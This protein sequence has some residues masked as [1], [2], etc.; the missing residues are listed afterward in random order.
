MWMH[1][2]APTCTLKMVKMV[3]VCILYHNKKN[4]QWNFLCENRQIS[5]ILE[6]KFPQL[7]PQCQSWGCRGW[8]RGCDILA[9]ANQSFP[10]LSCLAGESPGVRSISSLSLAH[11][12]VGERACVS[13][14]TTEQG[15]SL[16]LYL[17]ER[18]NLKVLSQP[19]KGSWTMC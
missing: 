14:Q 5:V 12:S 8:M 10:G 11:F 16:F 6:L 9:L 19:F 13:P 3:N 15:V 7:I 4:N 2:M 18:R 17:G 1:L